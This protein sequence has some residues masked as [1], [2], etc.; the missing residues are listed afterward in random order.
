MEAKVLGE[1][2]KEARQPT[3][4]KMSLDMQVEMYDNEN[5]NLR[6]ERYRLMQHINRLEEA[7]LDKERTLG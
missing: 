1:N 2:F 3:N 7:N 5:R 4:S 6:N